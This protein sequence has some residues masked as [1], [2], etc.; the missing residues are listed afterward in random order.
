[1]PEYT[2]KQGDCINSIAYEFGFFPNTIWNHPKNAS[3]KELRKDSGILFEGD[4][5]FV[6][7]KNTKKIGLN[8][9][10]RNRFKMKGVPARLALT[11]L[12]SEGQPRSGDNYFLD[13]DGIIIRDKLDSN[14]QLD[15]SISPTAKV[16]NLIVGDKL[17]PIRYE[18][19]LGY[20]DPLDTITGIQARL[21]N[22]GFDCGTEKGA[23][24]E[25]TKIAIRLFQKK[26]KLL[27]DGEIGNQFKE[28]LKEVFGR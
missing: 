18:I 9:D 21:N 20:L 4:K 22:L 7:E 11:I 28:K 8:Y 13:I 26:N 5:V 3:L 1:M 15:V 25:L 10:K 23:I 19:T 16:A 2:V 12:D 17:N 14:G 27:E 24:G 6:P